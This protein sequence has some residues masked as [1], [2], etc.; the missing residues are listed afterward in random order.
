M[1]SR[2]LYLF[3]LYLLTQEGLFASV[4]ASQVLNK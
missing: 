2:N 4:L 1:I 3:E